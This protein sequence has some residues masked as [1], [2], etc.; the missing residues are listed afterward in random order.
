MGGSNTVKGKRKRKKISIKP[1]I[2]VQDEP[3][4]NQ[5]AFCHQP[6][7]EGNEV[8]RA[9]NLHKLGNKYFHYFCVLFW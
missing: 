4:K 3:S 1:A 2:D 6:K 7:L 8:E 9:G 5:C